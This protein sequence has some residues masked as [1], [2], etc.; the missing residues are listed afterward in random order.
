MAEPVSRVDNQDQDYQGR[1]TVESYCVIS[2]GNGVRYFRSF[3]ILAELETVSVS[4]RLTSDSARAVV[5]QFRRILSASSHAV[6]V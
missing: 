5:S 1:D 4:C 6:Q 2:L 3:L